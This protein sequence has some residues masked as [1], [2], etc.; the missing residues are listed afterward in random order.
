[1]TLILIAAT[2][3]ALGIALATALN[4]H[5]L[6]RKLASYLSE[7]GQQMAELQAEIAGL[8]TQ[9]RRQD[10]PSP[11]SG[12]PPK[13]FNLNRRAEAVR[14]MRAGHQPNQLV[15]ATGWSVVEL[16]LLQKVERLHQ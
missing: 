11:S 5:Q 15:S 14:R 3:L 12:M 6:R 8:S 16:E 2:T 1:M 4:C 10:Q 13:G 7:M 9:V